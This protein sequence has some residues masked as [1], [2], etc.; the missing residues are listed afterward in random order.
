MTRIGCKGSTQGAVALADDREPSLFVDVGPTE[1]GDLRTTEP[2]VETE[3]DREALLVAASEGAAAR[4]AAVRSSSARQRP[5]A[6]RGIGIAPRGPSG[7]PVS[8]Q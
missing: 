6:R 1:P 7:R 2:G 4:E 3:E 8:V 5:F